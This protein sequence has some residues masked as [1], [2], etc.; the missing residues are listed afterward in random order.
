VREQIA[1]L[2]AGKVADR[3]DLLDFID[4][5]IGHDGAQG[6]LFDLGRLVHDTVFLPGTRGSSSLKKVLPALLA[7]S[8]SL[9]AKHERPDYGAEGGTPSLN[10]TGQAWIR[11]D[12]EGRVVDPYKL[13]GERTEDLDLKDL[14]QR[15]EDDSVIADGGAAMVAYGLLQN[16]LLTPDARDRL[17]RQLLRY[18]E[19]DTLAM[20]M[21]WE[22]LM[23]L[24]S[25]V[26]L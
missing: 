1:G 8:A 16:R 15:E 3:Q 20:V 5:L 17:R 19:L 14:E 24:R 23:E 6:R 18:C 12:E 25:V 22:G 21:A 10:F 2:D 26:E 7:S 4:D 11:Y 13:L 9:R